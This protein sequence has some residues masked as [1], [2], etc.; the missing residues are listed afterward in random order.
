MA[1]R[2][3]ENTLVQ[4]L[5]EAVSTAFVSAKLS[6][7][8]LQRAV[9]RSPGDRLPWQLPPLHTQATLNGVDL[10]FLLQPK[11]KTTPERLMAFWTETL[12][13][14]HSEPTRAIRNGQYVNLRRLAPKSTQGEL[15]YAFSEQAGWEYGDYSGI[16]LSLEVAKIA[17]TSLNVGCVDLDDDNYVV[18]L[19]TGEQFGVMNGQPLISSPW[20]CM[21]SAS[22]EVIQIMQRPRGRLSTIC[23]YDTIA[24]ARSMLH[25]Y[26]DQFQEPEAV[27]YV[28]QALRVLHLG[29][30][31]PELVRTTV[32]KP[33]CSKEDISRASLVK[34]VVKVWEDAISDRDKLRS[35]HHLLVPDTLSPDAFKAKIFAPDVFPYTLTMKQAAKVANY[36]LTFKL[37]L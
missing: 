29:S 28:L 14:L 1:K 2:E 30:H 8:A 31:C 5:A 32:Q 27:E 16:A 22:G 34:A 4:V 23:E 18:T 35:L 13:R 24:L 7:S 33:Y 26:R 9:I 25:Q 36:V 12:T 11:L 15:R 3:P 19:L 6:V 10:E 20:D 37:G 17:E 21:A